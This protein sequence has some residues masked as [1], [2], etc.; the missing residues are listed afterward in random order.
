MSGTMATSHRHQLSVTEAKMHWP[1]SRTIRVN[2]IPGCATISQVRESFE[3]V[4]CNV[5]SVSEL[6]LSPHEVASNWQF[7]FVT[8]AD[9][10][11]A[12]AMLHSRAVPFLGPLK[13]SSKDSMN[14]NIENAKHQLMRRLEKVGSLGE[15]RVW[16]GRAAEDCATSNKCGGGRSRGRRSRSRTPSGFD[17]QRAFLEKKLKSLKGN[18][19]GMSGPVAP[20]TNKENRK[21]PERATNISRKKKEDM[22]GPFRSIPWA[23]PEWQPESECGSAEQL[24]LTSSADL[25][26]EGGQRRATSKAVG[27]AKVQDPG[28]LVAMHASQ[29]GMSPDAAWNYSLAREAM[30][31]AYQSTILTDTAASELDGALAAARVSKEFS[32]PW[33]EAFQAIWGILAGNGVAVT[34]I[35]DLASSL[36]SCIMDAGM[37]PVQG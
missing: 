23:N 2:R 21:Q 17:D 11:S 13:A 28:P 32:M 24:A 29:Q 8:F 37:H 35:S 9:F 6:H 27:G 31:H 18:L 12:H 20:N 33:D 19:H 16:A 10:D 4:G 30:V 15:V 7:C 36:V 14:R 26:S 1:D 22:R 25:C 5:E 3:A 34:R